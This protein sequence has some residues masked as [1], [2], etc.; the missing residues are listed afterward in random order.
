MFS[1]M[2]VLRQTL[3]RLVD[4]VR[5]VVVNTTLWVWVALSQVVERIWRLLTIPFRNKMR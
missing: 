4:G 1:L 3:K 5:M 2:S